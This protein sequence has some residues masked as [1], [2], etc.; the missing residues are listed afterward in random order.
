MGLLFRSELCPDRYNALHIVA[1]ISGMTTFMIPPLWSIFVELVA[2]FAMPGNPPLPPCNGKV[3]I[4][5]FLVVSCRSASPFRLHETNWTEGRCLV[6][7][8]TRGKAGYEAWQTGP[9]AD[10]VGRRSVEQFGMHDARH[11]LRK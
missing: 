1:L 2:F 6:V 11:L 7:V 3:G 5:G 4:P 8:C 9:L 10:E